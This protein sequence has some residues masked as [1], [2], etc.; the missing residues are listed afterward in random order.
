MV[1]GEGQKSPRGTAM[2]W[3][4]AKR[5]AAEMMGVVNGENGVAQNAAPKRPGLHSVDPN[6][7]RLLT[8][9]LE[10]FGDTTKQSEVSRQELGGPRNQYDDSS[11]L[12]ASAQ[13]DLAAK[14]A[15]L[16]RAQTSHD[17]MAEEL[18]EA[19][20]RLSQSKA[21]VL[22]KS[23]ELA[24]IVRER[25]QEI[26]EKE[27]LFEDLMAQRA[28]VSRLEETNKQLMAE[29]V[30]AIQLQETKQAQLMA[31]R[32]KVSQLEETNARLELAKHD[33]ATLQ[34]QLDEAR[35]DIASLQEN[36]VQLCEKGLASSTEQQQQQH[37]LK[38]GSAPH[39]SAADQQ[40]PD[41]GPQDNPKEGIFKQLQPLLKDF[42]SR[43]LVCQKGAKVSTEEVYREFIRVNKG[44]VNSI[45][46]L[47]VDS[48]SKAFSREVGNRRGGDMKS[49]DANRLRYGKKQCRGYCNL[50]IKEED[51][52]LSG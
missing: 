51:E 41:P 4:P 24:A 31:E 18:A 16:A 45:S 32:A 27:K 11:H 33:N 22:A 34:A 49:V 44:I 6:F 46:T 20:E 10:R 23:N 3:V 5:Q 15:E 47:S 28:K 29:Q 14:D 35:Q 2:F 50:R 17:A 30:E 43:R 1:P 40:Q 39:S 21:M 8:K 12:L 36:I 38:R 52:C 48:F 9:E 37:K 26:E 13:Q 25:E 7:L 42:A 19:N